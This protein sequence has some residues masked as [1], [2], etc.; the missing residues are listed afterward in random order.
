M[1]CVLFFT[2]YRHVF[3]F[4]FYNFILEYVCNNLFTKICK[5]NTCRYLNVSEEGGKK[6]DCNLKMN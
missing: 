5:K 4:K 6:I 3:I 1:C 2:E